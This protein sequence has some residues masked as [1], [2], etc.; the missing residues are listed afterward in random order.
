MNQLVAKAPVLLVWSFSVGES[1]PF[2]FASGAFES[3]SLFPHSHRYELAVWRRC[4]L[5]AEDVESFFDPWA[6][7]SVR[8][9]ERPTFGRESPDLVSRLLFSLCPPQGRL[10]VLYRGKDLCVQRRL[11]AKGHSFYRV[12]GPLSPAA[13][14]QAR[15]KF[16]RWLL[17]SAAPRFR[18]VFELTSP[19]D[20]STLFPSQNGSDRS[21]FEE[22]AFFI[23]GP[24]TPSAWHK[25]DLDE[26]GSAVEVFDLY[27]DS[28]LDRFECIVLD[29]AGYDAHPSDY[30][31]EFAIHSRHMREYEVL[32]RLRRFA[33]SAGFNFFHFRRQ[34]DEFAADL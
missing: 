30:D 19:T 20:L 3:R 18:A 10:W 11:Q 22:C 12:E 27:A 31:H 32:A 5:P 14:S 15:S 23:Q 1:E 8:D 25:T 2:A 17:R 33:E 6:E 28:C 34:P 24:A 13:R 29:A 4:D 16:G 7:E 26:P 21:I 9:E